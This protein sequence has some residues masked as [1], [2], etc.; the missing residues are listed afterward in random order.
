MKFIYAILA[1]T[2]LSFCSSCK[3]FLD[4]KPKDFLSPVTYYETGDQLNNA[5]T[6]VYQTLADLN[7]YGNSMQGYMGLDADEGFFRRTGGVQV[8]NVVPS[9][10]MIKNLWG[11]FYKGIERANLLLENIDKPIMTDSARNVIKG[12]ALFLRSYFYFVLVSH[13]GDVPLKL[14]PTSSPNDP[15]LAR[16]PAKDVYAQILKD[17][18]T[19]EQLVLP[20]DKI[21][22]G[23]RVSKSAVEGIL[24]RV[25]LYMAGNPINDVSKFNDAKLW[26]QKVMNS[27]LHDL[28][29]SYQQVFINYAQDK[30]DIK[31]SIWEVEFWGNS[32]APY[33]QGGRVGTNFGVLYSGPTTNSGVSFGWVYSTDWLYNS[34]ATADTRRDWN[35]APYTL[36]NGVEVPRPLPVKLNRYAG[37]WYRKYELSTSDKTN[38]NTPENFPLL[39]YSDVLLMF[40][41][42]ENEINGPTSAAYDALNQVVRRAFGKP[43]HTS[44]PSIDLQG[45]TKDLMRSYIQV[46]RSK[47]LCFEGM[48]KMDLVRWGIYMPRMQ[49]GV[50]EFA[51]DMPTSALVEYFKNVK[52]RDVLWP[53]PSTELPLNPAMTQNP[54]W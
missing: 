27:G 51:M 47:E 45:M 9:D 11:T 28:N 54:G 30:Y 16:T 26:A 20:I 32:A 21:G 43:V 18:T 39:R 25:C 12:E 33:S 53:I 50:A 46:E 48:R 17:M 6:S 4:T 42:A 22:Y 2:L 36:S 31:E 7:T 41:E 8:N 5:L 15:P 40:A 3:K 13:F 24:A 29:P 23:G 44:Q 1:F 38:S 52:D 49:V 34:Y 14:T 10:P 19:A 37:K 35:I